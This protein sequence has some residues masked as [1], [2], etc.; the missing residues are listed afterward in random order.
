MHPLRFTVPA[1]ENLEVI[2]IVFHLVGSSLE[3]GIRIDTDACR[4]LLE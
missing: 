4:K 1:S 2:D 3:N